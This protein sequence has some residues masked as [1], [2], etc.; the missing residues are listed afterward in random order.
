MNRATRAIVSTLGPASALAGLDHG[1]FEA[2]QGNTPTPGLF[3]QAIGPGQRMWPN[4]T[5]DAFT[6]VPRFLV[7]G[8]LAIVL[9]VAVAV[10]SVGFVHRKRGP[11]VLLLLYVLLF[12]VGGGVAQVAFFIPVWLVSTR[13]NTPLSWWRKVLSERTRV[14]IGKAWRGSLIVACVLFLLG[15]EIAIFGF[16]PGLTEPSAIL[17]VNWSVVAASFV[18]LLFTFVAGF[19]H[20]IQQMGPRTRAS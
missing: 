11:A 13:V 8:I 10:W 6:L 7:S 3:V 9:S 4:G 19:A 18:L 15:L 14:A 12:L 16:V 2:L 5:E 17:A 20:D 1:L